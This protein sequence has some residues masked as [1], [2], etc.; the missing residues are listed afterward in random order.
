[1]N[2]IFYG[3]EIDCIQGRLSIKSLNFILDLLD[4]YTELVEQVKESEK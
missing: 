3:G 2:K 4:D 1:M